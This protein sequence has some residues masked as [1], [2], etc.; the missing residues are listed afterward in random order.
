MDA[1]QTFPILQWLSVI[2]LGLA[3][4]SFA[5][6]LATRDDFLLFKNKTRSACPQC[7]KP[8]GLLDLVPVFSW[9]LLKGRCRH[10]SAKIPP[11]YPLIELSVLL[12]GLAYFLL[13]GM[14][15]F[16]QFMVMFV[17]IAALVGLCVQDMRKK[18]L[19][20]KLLVLLAAAG[21]LYRFWPEWAALPYKYLLTE[22]ALAAAVYGLLAFALAFVMEKALK[23]PAMGMGDVKFFAV[24]GLWLGLSNLPAFCILGG[25]LGVVFGI[26]W[27]KIRKEAHFP[28][29]P[30]L[31]A[32][33]FIV[34]L[35]GSSHLL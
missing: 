30:A 16:G 13:R 27:Q 21:V 1:L 12:M 32:S 24:A 10:C 8:L 19:P 6:V 29:G 35:L 14:F 18:I 28:F 5:T 25:I 4:G 2:L 3:F 26:F 22:Y 15:P 31:I 34:F 9:L 23:K 33:F 7:R 17:A 11:A 20:N